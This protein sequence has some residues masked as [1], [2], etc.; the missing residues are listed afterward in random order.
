VPTLRV[1]DIDIYY[2]I[3]GEGEPL[4]FIHGLGSSTRDWQRQTA[5]FRLDYRVI[6]FDLRGHGNSDKPPGPYSI[7]LFAADTVA[8]MRALDIDSA[9]VVGMS[10][11]GM[12]AFQ[13]AVSAPDLVR[14]LV[15][16]NAAPEFFLGT[17]PDNLWLLQRQT[18]VR[19]MGMRRFGDVLSRQLFP[20]LGQRL[21]RREM[22]ERFAQND[23]RAY[24]AALRAGTEGWS[25]AAHL[26]DLKCP[27][28]VIAAS[29][30]YTPVELKAAYVAKIPNAE[31]VVIRNSRHATPTDQPT[32]FNKA[33]R[34]FLAARREGSHDATDQP[35]T[36]WFPVK[37]YGWGWGLPVR[38]QGWLVFVGYCALLFA[39]VQERQ[40]LSD[41]YG[42]ALY[43][44]LLT[45]VLVGVV[46][47]KGER[48]IAWRW[49]RK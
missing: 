18:M 29:R 26:Q 32:A 44:A 21:L 41:S 19:A 37:K 48:P 13:L 20:K 3:E 14:S 43:V 7:P 30:D 8:L 27:T 33:V 34:T 12:I 38:W 2:E 47:A 4:L 40:V 22:V 11:G 16:V 17:F 23:P 42:L 35:P 10:L 28:L 5:A 15:I 46:A 24:L 31:L 39:G 45:A 1:A 6:T 49:G 25:V 36:F 9:H